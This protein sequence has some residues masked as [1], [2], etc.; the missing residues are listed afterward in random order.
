MT[1]VFV[2][3]PQFAPEARRKAVAV[4]LSRREMTSALLQAVEQRNVAR[5]ELTA[6]D[7]QAL[8]AHKD[9][10][11]REQA[12]KIFQRDNSARS[13]VI[14]KFRPSLDLRGDGALGHV[15]YQQRCATCHRTGNEGLAVGPDLASVANGGKEKL[16]TS[17][18]DPNAEVAAAYVAYAVETKRDE[19]FLGVLAS[20]NPLSVMLKTASGESVRIARESISSMRGSD[21]SLM[22][23]GLEEGLST[24]DFADLLEFVTQAKPASSL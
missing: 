11:I 13:E 24:Q 8:T 16:L 21:K 23:E 17:I 15:I 5:T 14:K 1:N 9:G 4:A 7:I 19:S 10:G 22:P 6:S 2:R 20:E 12:R 3:W 18:L